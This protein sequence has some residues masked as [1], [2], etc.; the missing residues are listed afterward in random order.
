MDH[1]NGKIAV[2]LVIGTIFLLLSLIFSLV[3][4]ANPQAASKWAWR[5]IGG[6][7]IVGLVTLVIIDP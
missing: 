6:L 2:Q 5:V 3:F 1:N 4:R 7:L